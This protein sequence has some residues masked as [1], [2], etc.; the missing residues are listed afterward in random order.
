VKAQSPGFFLAEI[1]GLFD[2]FILPSVRETRAEHRAQIVKSYM[3]LWIVKPRDAKRFAMQI[4]GRV[5]IIANIQF[6]ISGLERDGKVP[7]HGFPGGCNVSASRWRLIARVIS[8]LAPRVLKRVT[9]ASPRLS[10]D[11]QRDLYPS[12]ALLRANRCPHRGH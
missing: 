5:N 10:N 4:N 6:V 12:A 2:I 9:R 7:R 3:V 11:E 1:N 8:S